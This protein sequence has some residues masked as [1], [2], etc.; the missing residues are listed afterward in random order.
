MKKVSLFVC[1][2]AMCAMAT[3]VFAAQTLVSFITPPAGGGAYI[4]GAGIVNVTNK[5][6]GPDVKF[7]HEASTG[8]M[9]IVRRLALAESQKKD[10]FGTFGATDAWKAQT[11]R[12]EFASKP[13][14]GL[15]A[16]AFSQM[17]DHYLVVPANSPIKSYRD[18]KGKRLGIGGP[19]SSIA[20]TGLLLLDLYG[21]KKEDFKPYYF[22]YKETIEGIKDGSLDGGFLAGGY[23]MAS[24]MELSTTHSVRIVPVEEKIST[25]LTTDYAGY[26]TSVVKAKLYRG[27]E[28]D[29]PIIGF[30]GALWT[31]S[32]VSND[33]AYR[34]IKN[35]FDHK[36]EYYKIHQDAKVLTAEN[37][38]K[39]IRV[40]FHPGAEKY[41]KEIGAMK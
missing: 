10:A 3:P 31:H 28:Q 32:G 33:L 35:L 40:P 39:T 14:P 21:V 17:V 6:I 19:G 8:T 9:E 34:F 11:G 23:P 30:S 29:T 26:Y 41:L 1:L 13:F 2:L 7:V 38:T 20:I 4:L 18:V 5:Y 12:D 15:R 36:E 37:A 22:V 24:Y 25:K 16:I 27:H